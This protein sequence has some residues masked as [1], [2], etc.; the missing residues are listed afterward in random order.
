M[1]EGVRGKAAMWIRAGERRTR[2]N[3]TPKK[4]GRGSSGW[5]VDGG[6]EWRVERATS[7]GACERHIV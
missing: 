6:C 1:R 2:G 4:D 3:G 5:Q 7:H